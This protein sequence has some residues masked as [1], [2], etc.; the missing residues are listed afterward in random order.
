MLT[1]GGDPEMLLLNINDNSAY[2]LISQVE[3]P[4]PEKCGGV[5][6]PV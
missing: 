5:C 6:D 1:T 3:T 4:A 2:C